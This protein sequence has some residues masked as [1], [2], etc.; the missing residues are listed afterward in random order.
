MSDHADPITAEQSR[1][2][3]T[4]ERQWQMY[5]SHRAR[6]E[7][8]IVPQDRGGRL[9]ALGAGN[10]NDLDLRWLTDVYAEVHLVDLDPASVRLGI[11]RQGIAGFPKLHVHAPFDLTNVAAEV[12]KWSH[13][14]PSSADIERGLQRLREPPDTPWGACD[15]VLSP[16]VLTQTITPSRD[17]LRN[18]TPAAEAAAK[19][20][21]TA[22]RDRHL[23]LMRDSLAPAGRGVLVIDLVSSEKVPDLARIPEPELPSA[24]D[25]FVAAA[26]HFRGLDPTSIAKAA[27]TLGLT[28]RLTPPWLWHLGLRKSFLVY[29]TTL[30]RS[31]ISNSIFQI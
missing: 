15:V 9:C 23:R 28:T 27:D 19:A 11:D 12:A 10:C 22:L 25:R 14:T 13:A 2:N 4:T 16:C 29:A 18:V 6:I 3:R 1:Q 24:M 8:L 31:T 7:R 21:R 5:A 26:K 30:T 20:F 17:T